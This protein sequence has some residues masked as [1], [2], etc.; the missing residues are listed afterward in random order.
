VDG[1]GGTVGASVRGPLPF[2]GKEGKSAPH[3]KERDGTDGGGEQTP[4]ALPLP[5]SRL[6]G[7]ISTL[8]NAQLQVVQKLGLKDLAAIQM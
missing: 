6:T 1:W 3:R 2:A 7:R 4:R 8:G 5:G